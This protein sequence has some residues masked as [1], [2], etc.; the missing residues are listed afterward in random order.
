MIRAAH[1]ARAR[2]PDLH[3][4]IAGDG[5]LRDSLA[6]EI[7]RLRLRDRVHL[8]GH[9]DRVD[10]LIAEASV[11]VL[12]SKSEGLGS[13]LLDALALARPVVATAAGGIPEILPPEA[14]VPVGAADALA[15]KVVDTLENPIPP[16]LPAR[17]FASVMAHGV[18]AVYRTLL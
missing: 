17:F 4:I 18:L 1:C 16:P 11:F 12:S 7:D 9:V 14:L 13:V 10:A 15:Q 3:W 6:A 5:N 8:I 2:R